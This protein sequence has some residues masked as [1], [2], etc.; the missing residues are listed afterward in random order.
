V[1]RID[2]GPSV[3]K[4]GMS[5]IVAEVN[6]REQRLSPPDHC[7]HASDRSTAKLSGTRLYARMLR[8]GE[9]RFNGF[10]W[11]VLIGCKRYVLIL[12]YNTTDVFAVAYHE[13]QLQL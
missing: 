4:E 8:V 1:D 11:E 6:S 10:R 12:L 5:R 3:A 13:S 7:D 9:V 2:N